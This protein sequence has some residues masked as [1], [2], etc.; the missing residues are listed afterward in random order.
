MQ[1]KRRKVNEMISPTISPIDD[2]RTEVA[3]DHLKGLWARGCEF[4]QCEYAILGGAMT[5]VSEHNLVAAISNAG[6]FGILASGAM[7][8]DILRE[9][10]KKT[11]SK[12]K[13]SFGV[14][15]ITL[16]PQL[17]D[18]IQVCIE[19]SISH[20]VLAG[21]VPSKQ[22]IEIL[23][24]A[25][26][27]IICFAPAL[28]LAKRMIQYGADALVIEGN[29]AGGHIGPVSTS[30]LAQEILPHIKNV[31]VFIAGGIG[32]GDIMVSYL[33][34]GASGCQLGTR[35]V[36]ATECQAHPDFKKAF[37]KGAARHAV[38]S[39]QIDPRL[40]V[41]PVRALHNMATE[42]FMNFQREMIKRVDD[43]LLGLSEAQMEIEH[44]WAGSLR[45]A[46][47]DGDIDHG[48]LMAGQSVGFVKKEASVQEIMNEL[49]GQAW[50]ILGSRA[51]YS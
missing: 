34:M 17:D 28:V 36:C 27:K 24:K 48:S 13:K 30:V 37:M 6:G 43:G 10:I 9:E 16:H 42:D 5:W 8:A 46:V 2:T 14:N 35:F 40:P 22:S 49:L 51:S 4:L 20:V 33:E 32:C 23:K 12:T 29:E 7:P 18:L 44:F 39:S 50:R 21:G 45:K 1:N 19:E 3:M 11:R 15:I 31:P 38:V 41:I 26:V 25:G 47:V